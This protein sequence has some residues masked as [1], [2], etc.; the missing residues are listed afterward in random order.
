MSED[1]Q[2]VLI[3][4]TVGSGKTTVAQRLSEILHREGIPGA[5]IDLDRLRECWPSPPGDPFNLAITLTNL[6]DV[7]ANF[8]AAGARVLIMAG[9]IETAEQRRQHAEAVGGPVGL[10]RL[11]A[12]LALIRRRLQRRHERDSAVRDWHLH[13]SGELDAILDRAAIDDLVLDVTELSPEQSA[14]RIRAELLTG[15]AR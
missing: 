6:R 12:D 7:A 1:F 2:A 5:L 3:N 13:R 14:T 11:T 8:R 10:V 9:V 4:G 15:V